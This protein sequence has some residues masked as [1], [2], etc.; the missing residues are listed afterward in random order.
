MERPVVIHRA[1]LGSLERFV[2]VYLE[3]VGGAFPFWLAPEQAIVIPIGENHLEAAR[4]L[5]RDLTIKGY[6][7]RVDDRNESMGKK[8][9]EAQTSKTPF[10]L[11]LGDNEVNEGTV[12]VRKYGEM[13]SDVLARTDLLALFDGLSLERLPEKFR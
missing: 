7:V 2:G 13:K 4:K 5:S 9:R 3:H 11:V 6:R 12:S 10:M 8:T 1:L